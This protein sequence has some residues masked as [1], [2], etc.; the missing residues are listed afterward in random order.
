ME[1][2]RPARRLHATVNLGPNG[3]SKLRDFL[4][5]IAGN[6]GMTLSA[7][8]T[9]ADSKR[10]ASISNSY[11]SWRKCFDRNP[12]TIKYDRLQAVLSLVDLNIHDYPHLPPKE[13]ERYTPTNISQP[14]LLISSFL[15]C[16][17]IVDLSHNIF[18]KPSCG[19]MHNNQVP[20]IQVNQGESSGISFN[21]TVLCSFPSNYGTH[22]D[23]PGHIAS[24]FQRRPVGGF[25]LD[26]F[27]LEAI[28]IDVRS[29]VENSEIFQR[30]NTSDHCLPND[31]F[32]RG[33]DG[34]K[35]L[36]DKFSELEISKD[37]FLKICSK[38]LNS[39]ENLSGKA[40][41]FCTGLDS[42][43]DYAIKP[44]WRYAYF[45]NPF[46]STDLAVYL[47]EQGVML[48]GSDTLQLE[49][50]L[51][52]ISVGDDFIGLTEIHKLMDINISKYAPRLVHSIFLENDNPICL[53]ENLCGLTKIKSGRVLLVAAP[54][55]L[56]DHRCT[57]NSVV[58][59]FA[60]APKRL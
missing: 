7:L 50:P 39:K 28:I 20:E 58:R 38:H 32:G 18:A 44:A 41:L 5:E 21:T 53:I 13:K 34:I 8:V 2:V 23:F 45:L 29:L 55:K 36:F 16:Y 49:C 35:K 15:N 4:E 54:L 46:L 33:V 3:G 31:A 37:F 27:V 17:D 30:I 57:D 51:F 12:G 14:A 47:A 10:G 9:E 43:W 22:I 48:V 26:N 40:V 24:H 56:A 59:A 6:K 52:N 60:F 42:Y 11:D 19:F 1:K 25:P